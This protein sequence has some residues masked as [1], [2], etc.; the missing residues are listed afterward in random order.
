VP[1][2][3]SAWE[4][5]SCDLNGNIQSYLQDWSFTVIRRISNYSEIDMQVVP[6]AS[7]SNQIFLGSR[8]I[9]AWRNNTP[10]FVGRIAAPLTRKS[11]N[12]EIK[13]YDAAHNM[14]GRR[15][16]LDVSA[17]PPYHYIATDA[18]QI[19]W[20][21]FFLQNQRSPIH[22]RQGT[23]QVCD[24]MTVNFN[25]D[26]VEMDAIQQIAH[27][28][29]GP[30]W[31]IDPVDST[32]GI[33]GSLN[34][35]AVASYQGT[36]PTQVSKGVWNDP[37][38]GSYY[39]AATGTTIHYFGKNPGTTTA[40]DTPPPPPVAPPVAGGIGTG[41]DRK[42]AKFEFGQNTLDN[43]LDYQV[44]YT[45]PTN[46]ATA[47]GA[48]S[49]DAAVSATAADAASQA[50]YD[51]WEDTVQSEGTTQDLVTRTAV[52]DL[53]PQPP[54]TWTL[55]PNPDANVPSLWDDF[56]A[57]DIV[58]WTVVDYD[59]AESHAGIVLEAQLKVDQSGVEQLTSLTLQTI[60]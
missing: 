27:A 36:G 44:E 4:V 53:V 37:I 60:A 46:Q 19:I 32:N 5:A 7:G 16:P 15:I 18:S 12:I 38:G 48:G 20:N 47:R 57:G 59:L 41:A 25:P 23:L 24:P 43:L 22:V 13:A 39:V 9:K 6:G 58:Y 29:G 31:R 45:M 55:T 11:D 8:I 42:A 33:W 51:L 49:A 10:R 26:M 28:D 52:K 50:A 40:V 34:T 14:T 3:D 30:W 56:D 35:W 17:A 54:Q 21:R 2:K 1:Y